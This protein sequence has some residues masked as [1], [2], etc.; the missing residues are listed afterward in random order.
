VLETSSKAWFW[1]GGNSVAKLFGGRGNALM[2]SK[3]RMQW[4]ILADKGMATNQC[5]AVFSV[6]G[7]LRQYQGYFGHAGKRVWT[8]NACHNP[9]LAS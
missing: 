7:V 9:T 3:L 1:G 5:C 4:L 6:D 8:G 2:E